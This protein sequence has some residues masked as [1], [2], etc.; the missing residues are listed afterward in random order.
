MNGVTT[1]NCAR[2][3]GYLIF[4][5]GVGLAFPIGGHGGGGVENTHIKY[6]RSHRNH[7]KYKVGARWLKQ[8]SSEMLGG[9]GGGGWGL[10]M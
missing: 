2:G 9:G 3:S 4:V 8:N 10:Y 1:V 6:T 7:R 5:N